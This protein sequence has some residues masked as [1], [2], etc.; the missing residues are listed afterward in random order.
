[1]NIFVKRWGI[2]GLL[3]LA[4]CVLLFAGWR[5]FAPRLPHFP[6]LSGWLLFAL[7]LLLTFYN[8]RK[9]IPF[10][11]AGRSEGWLLIH[12]YVGFLSVAV[13]AIHAGLRTP[14]GWFEGTLAWLYLLVT[15]SGIVG[16]GISRVFPERLTTR[17]GEVLFESIPTIRRA[18]RERAETLALDALPAA[19]SATVTEFYLAELQDFFAGPRNFF[20]HLLEVRNP[21]N[22]LLHRINETNRYLNA[23]ERKLLDQLAALVRQ[24]DGLDYHFA[25]QLALKLWLFVHIPLT[26]SL[27]IFSIVH[28]VL[29]FAYAGGT[30]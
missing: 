29:V 24:K 21:L 19:K 10:L 12:I 22:R 8:G 1:M 5:H 25:L 4:A 18:L 26:Y 13:F 16:L 7:M 30:P 11:P 27:L 2:G 3:L 23:D 15:A 20:S 28:V 9:K 6:Y 14:N 17:G